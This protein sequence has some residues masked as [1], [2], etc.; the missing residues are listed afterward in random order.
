MPGRGKSDYLNVSAAYNYATYVADIA[1]LMASLQLSK[2]HWIG[3]SMGGIIGMM[4]ANMYPDA[5][6]SLTLNDIGCQIPATGLKRILSYAGVNTVFT[7]REQAEQ[8]LRANCAPFGI[9]DEKHWH[10]LFRHGLLTEGSVTRLAYDPNIMNGFSKSEELKDLELW[11]LWEGVKKVR[12]L[13]IRGGMSDI[14]T[15]EIAQKMHHEH[16]HLRLHEIQGV[17]HAPALMANDQIQLI[18]DWL[19]SA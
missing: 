15:A 17:G 11:N 10:H 16:P 12:T 18:A 14:L 5:I 9:A 13:V 7:S 8:A 3:T 19:E 4:L 2:T 1:Y 6:L